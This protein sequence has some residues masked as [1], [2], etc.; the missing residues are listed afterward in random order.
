MNHIPVGANCLT[1]MG[2]GTLV[3][4]AVKGLTK[5]VCLAKSTTS[6]LHDIRRVEEGDSQ[7]I[8][9]VVLFFSPLPLVEA[10]TGTPTCFGGMRSEWHHLSTQA[11]YFK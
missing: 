8:I 6:L 2:V 1:L 5:S 10:R 7:E 3:T 9:G 11:F 4:F